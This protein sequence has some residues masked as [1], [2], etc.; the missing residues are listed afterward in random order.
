MTE[1]AFWDL[2]EMNG[3]KLSLNEKTKIIKQ[4]RGLSSNG[5]GPSSG[6]AQLN[7]K[8]ALSMLN[9]DPELSGTDINALIWGLR[10]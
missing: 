3:I 2:L 10:T 1:S 8:E 9:P 7:Y 5:P 4:C 6:S